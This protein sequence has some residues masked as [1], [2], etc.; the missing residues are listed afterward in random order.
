MCFII[1]GHTTGEGVSRKIE[2]SSATFQE[3]QLVTDNEQEKGSEGPK[4]CAANR[5][6]CVCRRHTSCAINGLTCSLCGFHSTGG[7]RAE[8]LMLCTALWQYCCFATVKCIHVI[9][10]A[11]DGS[12]YLIYDTLCRKTAICPVLY[13]STASL[14]T[15]VCEN[16]GQS[17]NRARLVDLHVDID[18]GFQ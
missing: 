15:I 11:A 18:W 13:L 3:V 12:W 4:F 17:D 6:G 16:L 9:G 10:K 5:F 14:E 2:N 7:E 8:L 1:S